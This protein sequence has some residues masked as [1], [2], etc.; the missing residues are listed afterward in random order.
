[1]TKKKKEEELVIVYKDIKDLIPA[2]YNPRKMSKK[3]EAEIRESL[4]RFNVVEPVVVN[5]HKDRENVIVGGHQRV[6]IAKKIG[7]KSIPCV[8]VC[9]TEELEREL[10]LRLNK[11]KAD[12]DMKKLIKEFK[13]DFLIQIGWEE[14]DFDFMKDEK[15]KV[16]GQENPY[17][18]KIEIPTYTPSEIKPPLS[19]LIDRTKADELIEEIHK[20]NLPKKEEQ[21]LLDAAERHVV[22]RF[23][24]IADYYAHSK[25]ELQELMEKSAL[26]IIDY[27]KAIEGG[28]VKL[29]EAIAQSFMED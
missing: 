20:Q 29:N 5:T 22:F 8:E 6:K 2:D 26:V 28:F 10:N 14:I 21:F 15:D 3:Q 25:P 9:L 18:Q 23:D 17:T 7:K 1:M 4:E 24:K 12:F 19:E 16:G 13:F 27:D 11:N